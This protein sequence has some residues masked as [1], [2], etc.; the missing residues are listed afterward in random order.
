ME[1]KKLKIAIVHDWLVTFRGGEKTLEAI[2][3]L[4]PEAPIYTLFYDKNSLP[5]QW[6]KKKIITRQGLNRL[7]FMR[8]ILLPFLPSAIESLDLQEY[9]LLISSSSC[10]AKG[11]IPSPQAKHICYLHSP[12]RYIWDQKSIYFKNLLRVPLLGFFTSQVLSFLR[13][14]DSTSNHRIDKFLSNSNF[15]RQRVRRYYR[16]SSQ[17]LP[18]PVD[19]KKINQ[20]QKN[21]P[22]PSQED[23][24]LILGAIVSYK[25][26]DLAIETFNHNQKKLFVIGSGPELKSLK[27]K[28]KRNISF[29][30]QRRDDEVI[31]YL[32][33]AK[34]LIFPGTEDFGITAI[35]AFACGT[36]VLAHKSGGALDFL[37]EGV[38]G[39]FF[40]DSNSESLERSLQTFE[41]AQ[42]H[43]ETI[44]KTANKYSKEN[45]QKHFQEHVKALIKSE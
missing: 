43:K 38:N 23:Y 2:S 40:K 42:F 21:R 34:A 11:L 27:S 44:K 25:N 10:V 32:S 16:R 22:S 29:L 14:W 39:I 12:M 18:P 24:Y 35:E 5:T 8:K 41:K 9:D 30:G 37:E 13:L 19:I 6:S 20:M 7:R 31:Q 36:P 17:I 26:F 15:V 4:Y 3:E 33:H 1:E 45:F 28:A